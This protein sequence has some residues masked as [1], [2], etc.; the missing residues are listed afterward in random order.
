MSTA[1]LATQLLD[2]PLADRV[3]LAQNLWQ[4]IQTTEDKSIDEVIQQCHQRDLEMTQ[5]LSD[6]KPHAKVIGQARQRLACP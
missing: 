3:F 1:T 4:S 5:G 6:G 2:L